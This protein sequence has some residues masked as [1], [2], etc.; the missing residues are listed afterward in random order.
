[1]QVHTT[2]LYNFDTKELYDMFSTYM[3]SF[4]VKWAGKE[5]EIE[6]PK[7]T[8]A[9]VLD[10][11]TAIEKVTGVATDCQVLLNINHAGKHGWLL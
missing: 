1:M 10:L 2:E 11:K 8:T 4:F 6:L 7:S 3:L 9:K 5:Y